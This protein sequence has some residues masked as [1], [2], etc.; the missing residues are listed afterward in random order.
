[1]IPSEGTTT[2]DPVI[3]ILTL[4]LKPGT[5]ETFHELYVTKSLPLLRRCKIDVVAHFPSQDDENPY[6]VVRSFKGVAERQEAE[7]AFYGSEDW[8]KGPGAAI[9][10][11]IQH[12]AYV[13]VSAKT[14]DEWCH[15]PR[16]N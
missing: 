15:S 1:M 11:M 8:R 16:E 6:Y 2:S 5:R 3:E 14:L 12:E 10:A 13:V 4:S 9:L 7:D